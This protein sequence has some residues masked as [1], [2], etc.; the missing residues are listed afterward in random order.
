MDIKIFVDTDPDIRLMRRIR[1]DLEQR[2]RTFQSVRD[3][4]YATVR[5]MHIEHVEPTQALGRPDRPRGRRQPRRARRAARPARPHR[6]RRMTLLAQ[7]RDTGYMFARM[8]LACCATA[9]GRIA[10]DPLEDS[11]LG[12]ES[13][14][15]ELPLTGEFASGPPYWVAVADLPAPRTELAVTADPAGRIYAIGGIDTVASATVYRFDTRSGVWTTIDSLASPRY[16][17][18]AATA[19][20]RIYAIGGHVG[21][22]MVA[23]VEVY[24]PVSGGGWMSAAPLGTA[25]EAHTAAVGGDGR[26]YAICGSGAAG[27]LRTVE[28]FDGGAWISA[29]DAAGTHSVHASTA[30]VL[31]RIYLFDLG[32]DERLSIGVGWTP[33]ASVAVA[34]RRDEHAAVLAPDGRVYQIGGSSVTDVRLQLVDALHPTTDTWMPVADLG[35]PRRFLGAAIGA[36]GRI[37][38]IGGSNAAGQAVSTVE[39][40]GPVVVAPSLAAAGEQVTLT[41][42]N[43][44]ADAMVAVYRGAC[45][46]ATGVTND[47]G[48]LSPPITFTIARDMPP[49]LE[50]YRVVDNRSGYPVTVIV[51]V[52]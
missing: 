20:G 33:I 4:Y 35:G 47:T 26:I 30:D 50:T 40:Y 37:Y 1:R 51:S 48:A 12:G 46:I 14:D 15:P 32:A 36:D 10:F 17:H 29:P 44:A 45:R 49:G 41:G 27:S 28:A 38:A 34:R 52:E 2:G 22:T 21:A 31:G 8:V 24:D 42:G 3:Q 43:F 9:C 23:S 39:A 5:P 7:T 19:N 18:A 11:G 6:V 13:C 16:F 25:R